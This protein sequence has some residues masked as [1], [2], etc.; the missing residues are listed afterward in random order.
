MICMSVQKSV[1]L[2][3]GVFFILYVIMGDRL[4][5]RLFALCMCVCLCMYVLCSVMFACILEV[6]CSL[7]G[8]KKVSG[9]CMVG[10]DNIPL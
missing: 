10:I 8:K 2:S 3:R 1:S 4:L 6:L 7:F 9:D 5:V